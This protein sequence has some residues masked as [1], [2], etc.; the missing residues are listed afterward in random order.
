V[1][2]LSFTLAPVAL[3]TLT[4]QNWLRRQCI[5]VIHMKGFDNFML[6]VILVCCSCSVLG[7]GAM[8]A[9]DTHGM[10]ANMV[11][12]AMDTNKPG[13]KDTPLGRALVV[14]SCCMP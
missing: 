12:L 5:R 7:G 6:G 4:K 14:R 9:A 2:D 8:R 10:Q 13:S 1:Q 11:T 3:F